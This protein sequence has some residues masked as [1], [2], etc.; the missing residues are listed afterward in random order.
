LDRLSIGL[1]AAQTGT[2]QMMAELA[3][4]RQAMDQLREQIHRMPGRRRWFR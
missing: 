4:L 2:N 3:Q 1:P